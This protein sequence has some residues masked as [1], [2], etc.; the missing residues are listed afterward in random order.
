MNRYFKALLLSGLAMFLSSRTAMAHYPDRPVVSYDVYVDT[1]HI[2]EDVEA[3][4]KPLIKTR[5]NFNGFILKKTDHVGYGLAYY[6]KYLP[7]I[8][9]VKVH[10]EPKKEISNARRAAVG[11]VNLAMGQVMHFHE[12]P[13]ADALPGKEMGEGSK[14]LKITIDRGGFWPPK[15]SKPLL[16]GT[17]RNGF[18][19]LEKDACFSKDRGFLCLHR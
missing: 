11:C 1:S 13:N 12:Y 4:V 17:G 10:L 16:K 15:E 2:P 6:N 3:V 18:Y 7:F 8:E 9:T 19:D 5:W 14:E